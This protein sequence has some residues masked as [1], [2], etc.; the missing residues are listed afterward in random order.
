[1]KNLFI[2]GS[3]MLSTALFAQ[4][5]GKQLSPKWK[6]GVV[7]EYTGTYD[8][9][10]HENNE[11]DIRTHFG[12]NS[13]FEV[14]QDEKE[15]FVIRSLVPNLVLFEVLHFANNGKADFKHYEEVN[16]FYAYNK[17]TGVT[18][19]LNWEN[20]AEIY[21]ECK[22]DMM[23]YVEHYPQKLM[24]FDG[25][26]KELDHKFKDSKSVS[27]AY[28][29]QMNW[30]TSFLGQN[31]ELNESFNSSKTLINPFFNDESL[32]VTTKS[33]VNV[34]DK[35]STSFSYTKDFT[36][37]ESYYKSKIEVYLKNRENEKL[38][39]ENEKKQLLNLGLTTYK[40]NFVENHT[41][42]YETTLPV[43]F[44]VEYM[45]DVTK[46]HSLNVFKKMITLNQKK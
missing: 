37:K 6:M 29:D 10:G 28:N 2:L 33:T 12:F 43:S 15:H 11:N 35:K 21:T 17:K 31:Y 24:K 26:L 14:I 4:N 18:E 39:S 32:E 3:L 30:F 36:V 40:P 41:I 19:L 34:V 45:L 20:L 13:N 22:S 8:Y 9:L 25:I 23:K 46:E 44:K 5:E 7:T 38:I 42:N 1:M 27:A 16:I